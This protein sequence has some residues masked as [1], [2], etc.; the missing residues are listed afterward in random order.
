[1]SNIL[2]HFAEPKIFHFFSGFA[3]ARCGSLT[4]IV[5]GS[6]GVVCCE[7]RTRS[8]QIHKTVLV[9]QTQNKK[10]D[11]PSLF[12]IKNS[13]LRSADRPLHESLTIST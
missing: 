8:A 10:H 6:R 9:L 11:E 4:V 2:A 1:M 3:V 13:H 5:V 7:K 12:Q